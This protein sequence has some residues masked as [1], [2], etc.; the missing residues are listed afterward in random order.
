MRT[1]NKMTL[2]VTVLLFI[3]GCPSCHDDHDSSVAPARPENTLTLDDVYTQKIM[4]LVGREIILYE[5]MAWSIPTPVGWSGFASPSPLP[6]LPYS[7]AETYGDGASKR[8]A[9][10]DFESAD[11]YIDD[12]TFRD[13]YEGSIPVVSPD[14]I[15]II[16]A[17]NDVK[18]V[19]FQRK[20]LKEGRAYYLTGVFQYARSS[21]FALPPQGDDTCLDKLNQIMYWRYIF[22][23][24]LTGLSETP[25]Q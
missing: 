11:Q 7:N 25:P 4:T 22:E 9:W 13:Q 2:C 23:F 17:E 10:L 18:E 8:R 19:S 14:L 24:R 6:C 15:T 21:W 16:S 3:M 12:P 5:D 1:T 20:R